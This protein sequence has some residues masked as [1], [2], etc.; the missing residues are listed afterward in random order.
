MLSPLLALAV[1]GLVS[2]KPIIKRQDFS[3][4]SGVVASEVSTCSDIGVSM[5][6]QGGTAADA[7]IATALCV[8]TISACASVC[9]L[10]QSIADGCIRPFL[11][12]SHEVQG[13]PWFIRVEGDIVFS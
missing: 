8:G 11:P 1:A 9:L 6:E 13:A 2:T 5:L 10:A 12:L 7:A 4:Q 3:G